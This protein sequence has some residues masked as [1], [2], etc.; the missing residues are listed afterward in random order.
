MSINKKL[1]NC[2]V[3]ASTLVS[4][5]MGS[6]K[7]HGDYLFDGIIDGKVVKFTTTYAK[8]YQINRLYVGNNNTWIEYID[9]SMNDLK[10][11]KVFEYKD[12]KLKEYPE[13]LWDSIGRKYVDSKQ[14]EFD[15]WLRIIKAH[16]DYNKR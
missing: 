10:I 9:D 3:I 15:D 1:K 7:E 5:V 16:Q 13:H 8:P 6:C 12:S 4:L 11:E 2:M 14:K